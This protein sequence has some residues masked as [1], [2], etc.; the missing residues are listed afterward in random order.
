MGYLTRMRTWEILPKFIQKILKCE[1]TWE[2]EAFKSKIIVIYDTEWDL[3]MSN[4][5]NWFRTGSTWKILWK[6]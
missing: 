1:I 3:R 4:A 2:K 6:Y 5:F